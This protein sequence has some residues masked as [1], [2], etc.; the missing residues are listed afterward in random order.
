MYVYGQLQKVS[1]EILTVD[2]AAGTTARFWFNSTSTKVMMDDGTNNRAML[3]N[4]QFC[5]F[6]NN[7]TAASNVRFNRGAAGLLQLVTGADVTAEGAMSTAVAQISARQENYLFANLPAFGNPGR[8]AFATDVNTLFV[9]NGAAWTSIGGGGGGS[10]LNWIEDGNSPTPAVDAAHVRVFQF[11]SGLSQG[12]YAVVKIPSGYVSGK[13][14]KMTMAMYSPDSSGTALLSTQSTL[15]RPGTDVFSSTANQLTS[16]NTAIALGAGTV[17]IPQN[18][19]FDLTDSTGKV[20][21]VT[22]AA[23]HYLIV[24]LF[25]GTDTG[26]SD[27][28]A[29]VYD[30]ELTFF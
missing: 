9:D 19:I 16:T 30:C 7:V 3:R 17:N 25:R 10:S 29:L 24:Q 2:P 21:G 6:G 26:T 1:Y 8:L 4:D 28:S 5:V 12:V 23:N 22:V 18:V 13:Q 14:I 11:Q 20:N 27:L 15:I